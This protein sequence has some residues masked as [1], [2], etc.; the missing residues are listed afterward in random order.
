MQQPTN[1]E[2]RNHMHSTQFTT[3]AQQADE[4]GATVEAMYWYVANHE[5]DEQ[6]CVTLENHF[7]NTY[8]AH[9][10][11]FNGEG[12]WQELECSNKSFS[13]HE[14]FTQYVA[15]CYSGRA[16]AY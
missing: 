12:E 9:V 6:Y 11:V 13:K 10:Y 5:V 3:L 14:A 1:T 7:N 8:G 4:R 2:Q 15:F 16:Y